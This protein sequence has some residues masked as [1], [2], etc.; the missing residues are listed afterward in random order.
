MKYGRRSD[1][2]G[3][4]HSSSVATIWNY[5]QQDDH[6][7][8]ERTSSWSLW[9][10]AE[11]LYFPKAW[12]ELDEGQISSFDIILASELRCRIKLGGYGA[13]TAN[14]CGGGVRIH[15]LRSDG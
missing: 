1:S 11:L 15:R 14:R 5:L 8:L 9:L 10:V 12:D 2:V 13:L 6:K 7:K 4:C 3:Y